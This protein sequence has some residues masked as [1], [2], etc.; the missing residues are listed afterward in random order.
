MAQY[1]NREADMKANSVLELVH[2]DLAGPIE[3]VA[4]R[5]SDMP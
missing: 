4:K 1:R 2:C 3:P 5:V